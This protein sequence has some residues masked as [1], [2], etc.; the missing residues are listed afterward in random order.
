MTFDEWLLNRY[1]C[2][3]DDNLTQDD[4]NSMRFIYENMEE[5][6]QAG[7]EEGAGVAENNTKAADDERL[8]K[9]LR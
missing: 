6:W 9:G 4:Y 3:K 8:A 2:L 7:F 1:A 5:A